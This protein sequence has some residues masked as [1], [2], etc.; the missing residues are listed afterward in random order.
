M[1]CSHND[2]HDANL[3]SASE[4]HVGI[5][6]RSACRDSAP[7][8]PILG[9][10]LSI[11]DSMRRRPR[12]RIVVEPLL[13]TKLQLEVLR[14]SFHGPYPAPPAAM[15]LEYPGDDL[16]L[17]Q[18]EKWFHDGEFFQ[19]ESI[20][21]RF[22]SGGFVA[23]GPLRL[24]CV[25]PCPV[26]V[27]SDLTVC[28]SGE[29]YFHLGGY[30]AIMLPCS[31]YYF[32]KECAAGYAGSAVPV[33][34]HIDHGHIAYLRQKKLPCF[35]DVYLRY[36]RPVD[37]ILAIKEKRLVSENQLHDPYL[38]ALLIALAQQQWKG[39]G[40]ERRQH[41]AGVTPK[42]LYTSDDGRAMHLYSTNVSA[43]M[44]RM[45]DDPTFSPPMPQSLSVGI[46]AIPYEP[47]ETLRDR[48]MALLLSATNL[49]DVGTSE[50]LVTYQ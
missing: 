47:L 46:I 16:L 41:A 37:N 38:V 7:K 5:D 9:R 50:E 8:P 26:G 22:L 1:T 25:S 3:F 42:V 23:Q 28:T 13:W 33:A 31:C 24:L 15:K 10:G 2:G 17:K 32:L 14:C 4:Q 6:A 20:V 34:A 11:R 18:F 49:D 19:R 27:L 43:T 36:S 45:F 30:R 29:L 12:E 39:L 48:M 40:V 21:V 44:I 35:D